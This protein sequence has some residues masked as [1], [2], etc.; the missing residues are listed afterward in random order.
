LIHNSYL[1]LLPVGLQDLG[2]IVDSERQGI[3]FFDCK[4]TGLKP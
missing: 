1:I 2:P 3:T 4:L